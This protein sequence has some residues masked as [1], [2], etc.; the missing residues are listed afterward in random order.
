MRTTDLEFEDED[1]IVLENCSPFHVAAKG[2]K[3][4]KRITHRISFV[5]ISGCFVCNISSVIASECT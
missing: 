4:A 5:A 3:V 2:A 1:N